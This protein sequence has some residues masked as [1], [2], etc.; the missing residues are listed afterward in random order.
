MDFA[1]I[2]SEH[3]PHPAPK[4]LGFTESP[5]APSA[6]PP[7]HAAR[8]RGG[9]DGSSCQGELSPLRQPR[10][11][12]GNGLTSERVDRPNKAELNLLLTKN[13]LPDKQQ[14][15]NLGN[16]WTK[17]LR[18]LSAHFNLEQEAQRLNRRFHIGTTQKRGPW[19]FLF[20]Q[21]PI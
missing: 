3:P 12:P 11:E 2:H 8:Q 17:S 4:L 14:S 5:N 16:E 9:S 19:P 10:N 6:G 13:D 18:I 1:T 20:C 7:Q 15:R 21:I